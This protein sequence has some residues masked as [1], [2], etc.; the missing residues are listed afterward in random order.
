MRDPD[1]IKLTEMFLLKSLLLNSDQSL[2]F[3]VFDLLRSTDFLVPEHSKIFEIMEHLLFKENRQQLDIAL[4]RN[5]IHDKRVLLAFKK[6]V[7]I[8]LPQDKLLNPLEY[9]A[10]VFDASRVRQARNLMESTLYKIDSTDANFDEIL[11]L[12]ENGLIELS[13][14]RPDENVELTQALPEFVNTLENSVDTIQGLST[15]LPSLDNLIYGLENGNMYVLAGRPSTGKTQLALQIM[16]EAALRGKKSLF[17]SL[18]MSKNEVLARILSYLSA[19]PLFKIKTRKV[20]QRDLSRI[21]KILSELTNLPLVIDQ[22]P[23]ILLRDIFTRSRKFRI[24]HNDLALIVVDYVQLLN[25]KGQTRENVVSE[26]SRGMKTLAKMLD[27][28]VLALSQLSRQCEYRED[29][30]PQLADLRESGCLPGYIYIKLADGR[31]IKMQ[32][33]FEKRKIFKGKS[34][35]CYDVWNS[36][37]ATDMIEDIIFN[38]YKTLFEFYILKDERVLIHTTGNH[39]I[40]AR[41]V[42]PTSGHGYF[43]WVDAASLFEKFSR[44]CRIDIL[45]AD[46]KSGM[47]PGKT[48]WVRVGVRYLG[49]DVL[50]PVFDINTK[51]HHNFIANGIVVHN[52]IEQ[53]ADVVMLLYPPGRYGKSE[54]IKDLEIIVAKNRNGPIGS[55]YAKNEMQIQKIFDDQARNRGL[56]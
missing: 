28:P 46:A 50:T 53:D 14:S 40:L 29:K 17:F 13:S 26:V 5:N 3:E 48:E 16:I 11:D 23:G 22:S 49:D 55:I 15:S 39:K 56:S 35:I 12:I 34:V 20:S 43:G 44:G 24:M 51:T 2:L 36:E 38:G 37:I 1:A 30:R 52:S 45:G 10:A 25:T 31:I 18:E 47:E 4:I 54:D 19:V 41:V 21:K 6:I 33:L 42:D 27:V 7:S 32:E 9:A 8:E